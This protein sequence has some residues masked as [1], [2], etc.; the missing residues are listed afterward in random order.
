MVG[1]IKFSGNILTSFF[2]RSQFCFELDSFVV[3]EADVFAYEEP[4]LLIGLELGSVNA[5]CFENR[6]EVF[7]Q[8]IIVWISES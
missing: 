6:E 2:G 7:R 4:R 1:N 5:L 8:S 3:V